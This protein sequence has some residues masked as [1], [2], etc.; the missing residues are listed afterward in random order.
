MRSDTQVRILGPLVVEREGRFVSVGGHQAKVVLAAL[1][2]GVNHTVP[3][4]QLAWALWQ[5][6]PPPTAHDTIQSYVSKL[7]H[8]LGTGAIER[9]EQ[10]YMLVADGDQIDACRFE[11]LVRQAEQL[12]GD[13]P[14]RASHLC[15]AA[16]GEWRGPVLG[17]IGDQEFA[18]LE[19]IRLSELRLLAVELEVEAELATGRPGEAT[20]RLMALTEEHPYRERLW[21]LLV[22]GLIADE[23][24]VEARSAYL[25]YRDALMECGVEVAESFEEFAGHLPVHGAAS[26]SR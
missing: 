4:D 21:R 17:A 26:S 6:S 25:R 10:S 20:S 13:D 9:E 14:E 16:L 5:D 3:S 18:H 15:R 23:R 2:I 8:V 11:R 19:A 12:I 7:R 1:V 22:H 24:R